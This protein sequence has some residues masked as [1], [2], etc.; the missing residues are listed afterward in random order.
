MALDFGGL[1][2]EKAALLWGTLLWHLQLLLQTDAQGIFKLQESSYSGARVFLGFDY[3][4]L[5]H[6]VI[7][8]RMIFH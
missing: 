7:L 2:S 8:L 4:T 5:F 6:S 1:L 3:N